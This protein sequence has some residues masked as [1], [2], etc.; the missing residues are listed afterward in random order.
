MTEEQKSDK[1]IKILLAEDD[2][3]IARAYTDGLTRSGYEVIAVTDGQEAIKQAKEKKPDI[4][5]LDLIMPVKNGF[6]AL[7]EIKSD[8]NMKDVPVL[9]LS[10]LGQDTDIKKGRDLGAV[11]YLIKSD[12]SMTEVI[13]KINKY[14]NNAPENIE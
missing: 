13:K 12:Y 8:K 7:E 3:F 10:N 14:L 6:E 2:K 9:I 5:L 1:K 11:D 4:I